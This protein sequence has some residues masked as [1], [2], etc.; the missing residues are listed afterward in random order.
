[1]NQNLIKQLKSQLSF[2]RAE[3]KEVE[4]I[5]ESA[6]ANMMSLED[7]DPEMEDVL[8]DF[9][10]SADRLEE[11]EDDIFDLESQIEEEEKVQTFFSQPLCKRLHGRRPI[12]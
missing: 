7:D 2:L 5:R 4:Q 12:F 9:E 6:S 11:I 1:M 3:W 10:T 8:F